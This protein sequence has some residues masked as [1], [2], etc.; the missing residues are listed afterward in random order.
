M[1]A[2]LPLGILCRACGRG[3]F[4]GG[5]SQVMN[6]AW[7][8]QALTNLLGSSSDVDLSAGPKASPGRNRP[9]KTNTVVNQVLIANA[10]ETSAS[11]SPV[12]IRPRLARLA[13]PL[14]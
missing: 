12:A 6:D 11:R 5:K 14:L 9:A 4:R 8:L 10:P 2:L 1:R 13:R 7:K 3:S